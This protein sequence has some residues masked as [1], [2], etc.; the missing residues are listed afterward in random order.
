MKHSWKIESDGDSMR[1]IPLC[2]VVVTYF[3]SATQTQALSGWL[4]VFDMLIVVD[5]TPAS[6]ANDA[7]ALDNL[8]SHERARVIRNRDNLGIAAALNIGVQTA[9]SLGFRWVAT[10]DQDSRPSSA[11]TDFFHR[12]LQSTLSKQKV[13]VL[14][15]NYINANNGRPG[16]MLDPASA[17]LAEVR[18]VI[19]SGSLLNLRCYEMIGGFCEKYFID[20]VD[21]EYCYRARKNGYVILVSS[22]PL[23]EHSV[24]TLQKIRLLGREFAFS[25]HSPL[26]QYYI[27]RNTLYMVK[28]YWAFDLWGCLQL[29]AIYLPKVWIKGVC[30]GPHKISS[31]KMMAKGIYEGLFQ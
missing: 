24:G 28:Q 6:A 2:A 13:G 9:Q 3:P 31:L 27:F 14:G 30:L 26:R 4:P 19:T 12:F 1:Q 20:M 23:M 7:L 25:Q 5:N 17:E 16:V 18:T 22:M 15:V 21:T 11:V 10:F 8:A 29:L